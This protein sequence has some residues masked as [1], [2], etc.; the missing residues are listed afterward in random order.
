LA[1]VVPSG[2]LKDLAGGESEIRLMRDPPACAHWANAI[3]RSLPPGRRLRYRHRRRDL[4]DAWFAPIGPESEVHLVPAICG[5][6]SV[7]G[8]RALSG[9]FE[10]SN[11]RGSLWCLLF[12]NEHEVLPIQAVRLA[13]ASPRAPFATRSFGAMNSQERA[14]RSEACLGKRLSVVHQPCR[15]SKGMCGVRRH[16]GNDRIGSRASPVLKGA[17]PTPE[18][19]VA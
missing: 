2:H 3:R 10:S 14:S 7:F 19:T 16:P 5:V 11:G 18:L 4:Q 17:A 15:V 1:R 12:L 8:R 9:T 6:T 13:L